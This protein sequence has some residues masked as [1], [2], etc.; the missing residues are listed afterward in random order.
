MNKCLILG[1]AVSLFASALHGITLHRSFRGG[2]PAEA[3]SAT[4]GDVIAFKGEFVS[5][6]QGG[7]VHWTHPSNSAYK[8]GGWLKKLKSAK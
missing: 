3:R 1:I 6:P 8:P 4:L 2:Y 7:V 5:N